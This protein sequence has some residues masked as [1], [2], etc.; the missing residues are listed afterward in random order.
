M[1]ELID[2]KLS[3]LSLF[4]VYAHRPLL[5]LLRE[6]EFPELKD[7]FKHIRSELEYILERM[8]PCDYKS[9]HEKNRELY[10]ELNAYILNP[11][12]AERVS[13]QYGI[14]ICDYLDAIDV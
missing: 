2:I 10:R 11:A 12:R 3:F 5:R 14:D 6:D 7:Y 13:A 1:D 4:R 9:M 8:P